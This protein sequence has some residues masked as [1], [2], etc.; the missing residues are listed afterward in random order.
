M[1]NKSNRQNLSSLVDCMEKISTAM[2]CNVQMYESCMLRV[3]LIKLDSPAWQL[4]LHNFLI[5]VFTE[6]CLACK[7]LS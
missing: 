3:V 4:I 1:N 6:S 7:V 5:R 2:D